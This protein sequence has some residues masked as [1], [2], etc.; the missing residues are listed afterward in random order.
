MI[1]V[2]CR[3]V[4][5]SSSYLNGYSTSTYNFYVRKLKTVCSDLYQ[6]IESLHMNSVIEQ[7]HSLSIS[8]RM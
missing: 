3:T 2:P 1:S 5:V 4:V 8:L 6:I 7:Y